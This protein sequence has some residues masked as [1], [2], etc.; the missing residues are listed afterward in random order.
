MQL[1]KNKKLN[2]DLPTDQILDKNT[3]ISAELRTYAYTVTLLCAYTITI[4]RSQC[5]QI[6]L[7]I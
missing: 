3:K 1:P 7:H 4:F 5:N 6:I 2:T